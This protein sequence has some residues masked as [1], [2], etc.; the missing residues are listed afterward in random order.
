MEVCPER[1]LCRP[2]GD[3]PTG[4]SWHRDLSPMCKEGDYILGGWI[5]LDAEPQYFSCIPSTYQVHGHEEGNMR[6]GSGFFKLDQADGPVY[7]KMKEVIE[8]PPG[9]MLLFFQDTIHEVLANAKSMRKFTSMRHFYGFR[10]T[11]H[12][13]PLRGKEYLRRCMEDQ[14]VIR[15]KSDQI[16][17]IYPGMALCFPKQTAKKDAWIESMT[18]GHETVTKEGRT[19]KSLKQIGELLGRYILYPA[20]QEEEVELLF[21]NHHLV[22]VNPVTNEKEEVS[23]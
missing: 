13:E 2:A 11:R 10:M 15:I 17:P 6:A 3:K 16:P 22:L 1:I 12:T 23:F 20:Y 7:D 14:S 21:P 19:F 9:G 18:W 4:E 5:N 8:I